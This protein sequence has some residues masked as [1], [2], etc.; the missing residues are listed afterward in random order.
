MRE[1]CICIGSG[2]IDKIFKGIYKA[3][4]LNCHFVNTVKLK[5]IRFL[6]NCGV[7][8]PTAHQHAF[9]FI[10]QP[11]M[12]LRNAL[13][14]KTKE[15]FRKETFR[16]VFEYRAYFPSS[17]K[18]HV[19]FA[20]S[21]PRFQLSAEEI[22]QRQVHFVIYHLREA[23][24]SADGF[25]NTPQM[26]QFESAK[27]S[28]DQNNVG[29]VKFGGFA[30]NNK[31]QENPLKKLLKFTHL[32]IVAVVIK[33]SVVG[34]FENAEWAHQHGKMV[35]VSSAFE[36]SLGLSAYTQF[37][38]Y[39]KVQRLSTFKLLDASRTNNK[40]NHFSAAVTQD[41]VLAVMFPSPTISAQVGD[42]LAIALTNKLSTEGTVTCGICDSNLKHAP[43]KLM[44][45]A[46][47]R[48]LRDKKISARKR[49]L[50][51]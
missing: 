26:Q 2:Y 47:E 6:N 29:N 1:L 27:F 41:E 18:E 19:V 51:S 16:F 35:V 11:A 24:D 20:D 37:P 30:P 25:Q 3:Y 32:G 50:R 44:V 34:G 46:T 10:R 48:K 14:T 45:E 4:V 49:A 42:T 7:D 40:L 21:A 31:I 12:I 33:P 43:L 13:N 17:M 23:I 36:S 22:L 38:S 39:L 28:I 5:H 9:I 15:A 8:L